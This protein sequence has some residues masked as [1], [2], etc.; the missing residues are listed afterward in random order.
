MWQLSLTA[1][2]FCRAAGCAGGV[3]ALPAG[4]C[5]VDYPGPYFV[6]VYVYV[7]KPDNPLVVQTEESVN[8]AFSI[9][10]ADFAP[11]NIFFVRSCGMEYIDDFDNDDDY[12][13]WSTYCELWGNPQYQ[14]DDGITLFFGPNAELEFDPNSSWGIDPLGGGLTNCIPGNQIWITG[15]WFVNP[16]S[17]APLP[18]VLETNVISHEMGH[19]LGLWH[20]EYGTF[21]DGD[22]LDYCSM[23]SYDNISCCELVDTGDP[24]DDTGCQCGD[25]VDDTNADIGTMTTASNCEW[26]PPSL[27]PDP[28]ETC[29]EVH[30]PNPNF[31]DTNGNP[32]APDP[33]NI[34]ANSNS[35][36]DCRIAFTDGQGVRMR[37]LLETNPDLGDYIL[38]PQFTNPEITGYVDWT[39]TNTPGNGEFLVAGDLTVKTGGT[40]YVHSGVVA[41]F[42]E[43]HKVIVEPGAELILEGTLTGYG[44]GTVWDGVEV[45]GNK[46]QSQYNT[47]GGYAQGRFTGLAGGT[48]ENA[49]TAVKLYGP[50]YNDS[51]GIINCTGS[52]FRNNTTG[53]V[54]A[55]YSN[56]YPY[57]VPPGQQGQPRPYDGRISLC[58]F[59]TDGDYPHAF[60]FYAF[61]EMTRVSGVHIS[62][63]TFSN[64]STVDILTDDPFHFGHGIVSYDANF[65]LGGYLNG[66]T[67]Q[68]PYTRSA[69]NNLGYGVFAAAVGAKRPYIAK[70][71]DFTNCIVGIRN[72]GVTG[73]T[74]LWNTFRMGLVPDSY[75]SDQFGICFEDDILRFTCEENDFTD[76]QANNA[77]KTIGIFSDDTGDFSKVI[78][79]NTF[80]DLDIGNL[81]NGDNGSSAGTTPRGLEYL[82]NQNFTV[83]ASGADFDVAT[84]QIRGTQGASS[85]AAGN[86]FSYTGTD[87]KNSGGGSLN[88]FY[89]ELG[90]NQEP[91]T[92]VGNVAKD[93]ADENICP[94]IYCE[95][96]CLDS[97]RLGETKE[98]YREKKGDYEQ[99]LAVYQSN[100][101]DAVADTLGQYRRELDE[102]AYLVALHIL[103]D[104]ATYHDDSLHTWIGNTDSYEGELWLAREHLDAGNHTTAVQVL[105]NIP[106]LHTLTTAQQ[107]DLNNFTAI[108]NLIGTQPV[109]GLD[110]IT[111]SS[112]ENYDNA[113]GHAGGWA[114]NIL[115][116]YGGHYPVGYAVSSGPQERPG[117]N[118]PWQTTENLKNKRALNVYPNPS[119]GDITFSCPLLEKGDAYLLIVTDMNGRQIANFR[120]TSTAA[121]QVWDT[122]HTPSGVYFYRYLVDGTFVQS[123]KIIL[124]K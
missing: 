120:G 62:G 70:Q 114:Q 71:C 84:G 6:K 5:G 18:N 45:W 79:K 27:T 99:L 83:V 1:Q 7:L 90:N 66:N 100:P 41:H 59:E 95:P 111:L 50:T 65:T 92:I 39:T 89:Y 48:V 54:F 14:H 61:I 11:H 69:F 112:V 105:N 74:I 98:D 80:S 37:Y 19:A 88:Y 75:T 23:T 55:P 51:G 60:P 20:T 76:T 42:S 97:E 35:N 119:S 44:C 25:F 52:V 85:S 121:Q 24:N 104:T 28:G 33:T 113:G 10:A 110:S 32:Y 56:T 107:A 2:S 4:D 31:V 15:Q 77:H 17:S 34:M 82:C 91:E 86:R 115:T 101:T 108:T 12:Y 36:L 103:Y 3:G 122:S 72:K 22:L 8:K 29:Y 81:A 93:D 118:G 106:N 78:R 94:T 63:S 96:P 46:N 67:P 53:I 21:E 9:L 73:A 43:G 26:I 16:N 102:A 58:T 64:S 109:Y 49:R 116:Y 57:T 47:G 117:H 13:H 30:P 38:S 40:L 124:D 123:G 68:G 87:F